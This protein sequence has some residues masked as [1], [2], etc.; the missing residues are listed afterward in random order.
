[1]AKSISETSSTPSS[2]WWRGLIMVLLA[3]L[4]LS[5]QN[6]LVR[7]VQYNGKYPLKILGGLIPSN[8]YVDADPANPLQVPLLV[9]L[10]RIAFVVPLLWTVLPVLRPGSEEQALSVLR[11]YNPKL[12][13]KVIAAGLL[14]FLSQTGTYLAVSIVGPATAL[15]V[16]FIYPVVTTLL[17]WR[18]F[19]DRPSWKQWLAIGLIISGCTWVLFS[20]V[21]GAA[22]KSDIVGLISAAFA[23]IVFALEG[24][25]AQSCFN[26]INPA[27]FTGLIFTVE[28]VI[29][30]IVCVAFIH[31]NLSQGLI[32]MGLLLCFSTLFGYLFNN[33]GIKAIGAASTAIIGSSGPAV[34]AILSVLILNDKIPSWIAI[35]L[36]TIG[37]VL[38]N[39]E[40]I[41]KKPIANVV[42]AAQEQD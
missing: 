37:V 3:T 32:I 11:G 18:L 6:V 26:K 42:S 4:F 34:T 5:I 23:G 10:V 7:I 27:T 9:L 13:M 19:G 20:T 2:Q 25:I 35:F 30:L 41:N 24:V 8:V 39:L 1:M 33:F 22:F 38:M 14:L 12:L 31:I 28:F 16:F 15:T 21:P 17:A 40:K 36:V 29:L